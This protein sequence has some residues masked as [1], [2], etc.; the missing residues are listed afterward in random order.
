M[1]KAISTV[2]SPSQAELSEKQ[3][4]LDEL[5]SRCSSM[6]LEQSTLATDISSF[7]NRYYLRVGVLYAQL[8]D[9]RAKIFAALAGENPS[10]AE[11]LKKSEDAAKHASESAKEVNAEA[12]EDEP[13]LFRPS[14]DLKSAYRNAV[15]LIHPDRAKDDRDRLLRDRL[16]TDLNYAYR[17]NDI[18][19]IS[20]IVTQ[21]HDQLAIVSA[22]DGSKEIRRFD[23]MIAKV[24]ARIDRL[25]SE[26]ADLRSCEWSNLIAQVSQGEVLGK[27][28]LGKLA[29][30]VYQAIRSEQQQLNAIR[31]RRSAPDAPCGPP[32][33]HA[34]KPTKSATDGDWPEHAFMPEGLIHRTDR[35]DM[36]RSKSEMIIANTLHNMALDYRYE[37]PLEGRAVPGVR[38]PDFSFVRQGEMPIIWEHLGMLGNRAYVARWLKK[39]DWYLANG[40]RQ[41]VELFVTEDNLNGGLDSQMIGDVAQKIA[42]ILNDSTK[43]PF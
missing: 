8:D 27:D 20:M 34:A 11:A 31:Q 7:R 15:R 6:E 19:T 3:R 17:Q 35:G 5:E 16:M 39:L 24:A 40:Y 42:A 22:G 18:E 37:F 33:Q 9:I 1:T 4:H 32:K 2:D 12:Q 21:Y 26:I 38:R 10:D 36:V 23:A 13:T 41:G 43:A 29:D 28:V 25:T 30:E 14:L